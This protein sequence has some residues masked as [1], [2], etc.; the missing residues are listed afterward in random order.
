M[1]EQLADPDSRLA[2]VGIPKF[3]AHYQAMIRKLPKPQV[4]IGHSIGGLIAQLLFDQEYGAAG[5]VMSSCAVAWVA[6]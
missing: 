2:G 3:V 4:L 1:D 6:H 5:I